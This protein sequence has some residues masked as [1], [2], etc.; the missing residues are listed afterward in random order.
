MK[1]RVLTGALLAAAAVGA[2]LGYEAVAR[3]REYRALL[4]QG[5]QALHGEQWFA[6]VEAYSGA[7]AL[8][9]DSMVAHLRRGETYQ[10]RGDLDAAARDF[11]AAATLDPASPQP[12]ESLGDILYQRQWFDRAADSYE[13]Y[14][15]L[16]D[17]AFR[18]MHKLALARYRAGKLAKAAELLERAVR[19]DDR[20][21]DA[22]YLLGLCLRDARRLAEAESAFERAI[23]LAPAF[24][25]AREELA[26]LYASLGRRSD[27]VVQLQVLAGLDRGRVE[28]QVALAAAQAR[29]G[30]PDVAVLTLGA[31]LERTPDHP[32]VY[33]ALGHVWLDVAEA[34]NDQVALSKA[35][36]ALARASASGAGTSE[37]LALYGRALLRSNQLE[38]ASRALRQA[39]QRYPV[40]PEAYLFLATVAE[41]LGDLESARQALKEYGALATDDPADP[42]LASRALRIASLSMRLGDRATAATWLRRA[43][44]AAPTDTRQLA[45]IAEAQLKAGDQTAAR[46][47]IARGLERA[48]RSP[49]LLALAERVKAGER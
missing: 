13:A 33:G 23:A 3:A 6:A 36:E 44:E 18:V 48:P 9:P 7:L 41:R 49:D 2:A 5:D 29:S 31:A 19:L 46:M 34:R 15:H 22:E 8:R 27:E 35:L 24:I 11:R 25:P 10:R 47:T 4:L 38:P 37:A 26:D 16:D 14:L 17:R 45:A 32:L 39:V 30:H 28:R 40:D 1:R 43:A 21:A 12:L 20:S 42:A